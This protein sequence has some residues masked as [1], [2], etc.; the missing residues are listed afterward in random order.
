MSLVLL[1]LLLLL[2]PQTNTTANASQSCPLHTGTNNSVSGDELLAFSE[3]P[4]HA[5][6]M[7]LTDD[8]YLEATATTHIKARDSGEG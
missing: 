2:L 6:G 7:F 5:V 8:Y 3:R 1:L 4:S